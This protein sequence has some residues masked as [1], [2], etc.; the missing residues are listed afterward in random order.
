[1]KKKL[2]RLTESDLHKIVKE[3]VNRI[4]K[5]GESEGWVVESEQAQDAYNLACDEM[6]KEYVDASIVRCLGDNTLSDCLA[7]LF[8]MWDFREWNEDKTVQHI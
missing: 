6:G 3:S 1:M 5:E 2:M 8:R 7:Y 4:L